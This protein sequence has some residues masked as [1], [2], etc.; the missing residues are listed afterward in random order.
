MPSDKKTKKDE[1]TSRKAEEDTRNELEALREELARKNEA[2]QA[3]MAQLN[4]AETKTQQEQ[5]PKAQR[6]S[7]SNRKLVRWDTDIDIQLMLAI[8]CACNEK[9]TKI[10]WKKVAEEL[11]PEFTEGAIVQHLGELRN[12]R[13]ELN[14]PVPTMP[15]RG[16]AIPTRVQEEHVKK[17]PT[18]SS[19]PSASKRKSRDPSTGRDSGDGFYAL[20]KKRQQTP[21]RG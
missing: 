10:P 14:K 1:Q 18:P 20:D 3:A 6:S 8:H 17:K 2:L 16:A 5:R 19:P 12:E 13:E 9:G 11:G 21:S 15:K 4:A 7:R